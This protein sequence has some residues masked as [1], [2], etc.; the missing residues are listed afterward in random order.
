MP[1]PK[2]HEDIASIVL[3]GSFNP[4]IF[5]PAWL[6]AKGLIRESESDAAVV[7]LIHPE[8]AQYSAAWLHVLVT[9][10]RYARSADGGAAQGRITGS[11]VRTRRAFCQASQRC[12]LRSE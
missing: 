5:Q 10:E 12:V 4:A 11:G 3:V 2:I 7:E 9:R 8:V 6:A 1:L